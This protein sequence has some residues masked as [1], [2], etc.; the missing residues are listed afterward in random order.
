VR[1]ARLRCPDDAELLVLEGTAELRCGN[2]EAALGPLV[3]AVAMTPGILYGAPFLVAGDALL[4]LERLEEAEDAYLRFLDFNGSSLEGYYK[5][6]RARRGLSQTTEARDSL[7]EA[8]ETWRGIPRFKK[9]EQLG[10]WL[11]CEVSRLWT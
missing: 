3:A 2:A 7:R 6:A 5:L 8:R 10:W 4:A 11:A 1:E 9:R